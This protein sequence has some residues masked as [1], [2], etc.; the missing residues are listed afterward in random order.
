METPFNT[1]FHGAERGSRGHVV[2]E[3]PAWWSARLNRPT[4]DVHMIWTWTFNFPYRRPDW[5][6]GETNSVMRPLVVTKKTIRYWGQSCWFIFAL[7]RSPWLTMYEIYIFFT[8]NFYFHRCNK[9]TSN[10]GNTI[11]ALNTS[12]QKYCTLKRTVTTMCKEYI[13]IF[14]THTKM[15]WSGHWLSYPNKTL[16]W[17][18]VPCLQ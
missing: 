17:K 6:A 1:W 14:N 10:L 11:L 7:L 12:L 3:H 2:S 5:R 18:Y 15:K 4:K 13:C 9:T 8:F 16:F